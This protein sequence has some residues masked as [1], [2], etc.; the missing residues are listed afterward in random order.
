[1]SENTCQFKVKVHLAFNQNISQ[2]ALVCKLVK[3]YD[4]EFSIIKANISSRKEGYLVLDL[5]GTE[6]NCEKAIK[7]LNESSV[8]VSYVA[9]RIWHDEDSCLDCGA[10][11]ALCPTHALHMSDNHLVFDKSK[12]IICLNCT[13]ICPVHALKSDVDILAD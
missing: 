12:C 9:Q 1:M 7:F 4:I 11:M 6:E 2:E 13:N 8:N 10:C 5:C 3:L